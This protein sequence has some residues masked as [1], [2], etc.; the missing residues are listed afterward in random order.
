MPITFPY[1]ELL[2]GDLRSLPMEELRARCGTPAD[3][4][5]WVWVYRFEGGGTPLSA[6]PRKVIVQFLIEEGR[7]AHA[8]MHLFFADGLDYQEIVW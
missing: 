5:D 8:H 2:K 1:R 6:D 4:T 3:E 7:A